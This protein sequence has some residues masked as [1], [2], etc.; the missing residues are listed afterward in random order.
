VNEDLNDDP[1]SVNT[2]PYDNGWMV[3]IELSENH[4]TDSLLNSKAYIDLIG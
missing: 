2:S 4:S 3:K 1:E